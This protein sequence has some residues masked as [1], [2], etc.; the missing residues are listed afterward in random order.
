[1]RRRFPY[2]ATAAILSVGLSAAT[3]AQ[4]ISARDKQIGAQQHPEILSQF[5]GPYAGP[6]VAMVDRVGKA[7]AVQSGLAKTGK[8]CTV[9]T[10]NTNVVNA[11]AVPGCYIYV[12]RGLLAIMDDE[13][14][15]AS[16]LGHEVGHVAA[17]HSQ[18][19][20]R[21]AT[22]SGL[23]SILA[24]VVLGD[25]AGQIAN[26]LGQN[27]VQSY[28]RSQEF[29]ADDL[30]VRFANGAGYD[31]YAAADMLQSLS[32]DEALQNKLLGTEKAASVPA[33]ARSHPLTQDRVVRATA[34][35][36]ATGITPGAKARNRA[37]YLA[38]VN[39]MLFGDDPAQGFVDDRT[40]AHPQLQ[41][42]FTAPPGFSVQNG[43]NAVAIVRNDGLKA[44]FSGGRLGSGGLEDYA[45]AVARQLLG[46]AQ[47]VQ[48]GRS[49]RTTINGLEA[50]VLP[51]RVDTQR[52]TTDVTVTAYRFAADQAY[53]FTTLAPAGQSAAFESLTN[54]FR[55]L[56]ATE[57]GALRQKRIEVVTAGPKDTIETLAARMAFANFRVERFLALND[58][59][60][61]RPIKAGELVKI[62]S[63]TQR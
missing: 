2:L 28:S 21:R 19:R 32:R 59:D 12:T 20:Q 24:N 16:V 22:F 7:V 4:G 25:T 5:G 56:S 62:I 17:R 43:P 47:G 26:F 9:T 57:A 6:G 11:F 36:K 50:F 39:G 38:A 52:G 35:A 40:F 13:A 18:K 42:Q 45:S 33:F 10:L 60:A 58:R 34:Q 51:L 41:L 29:E 23:G 46:Q 31:P 3:A 49:A 15:L 44:Q 1:M 48:T 61:T 14:E 30:G 8:E 55:R 53:S 37:Q 54:S 63:Y 27:L